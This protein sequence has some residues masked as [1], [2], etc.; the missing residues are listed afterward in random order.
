MR[1]DAWLTALH[2][3]LEAP[4]EPYSESGKTRPN[5]LGLRSIEQ[6]PDIGHRPEELHRLIGKWEKILSHIK[7]SRRLIFGVHD[8]GERGDFAR[9]RA[10]QRVRQQ[11]SATALSL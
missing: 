1:A 4:A 9:N 6:P 10:M 11:K 3:R 7:L 2:R 5:L 8:K